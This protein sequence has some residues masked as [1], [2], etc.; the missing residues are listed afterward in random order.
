MDGKPQDPKGFQLGPSIHVFAF[1]SEPPWRTGRWGRMNTVLA[2]ITKD[3]WAIWTEADTLA[4][5]VLRLGRSIFV[6][7]AEAGSPLKSA[8][9]EDFSSQG[10]VMD[11]IAE[12]M[13]GTCR[14]GPPR[15]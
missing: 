15:P 5:H 3:R 4:G 10:V 14:V 1:L 7:E 13:N 2:P 12:L 8:A 6:I 9:E 11:R